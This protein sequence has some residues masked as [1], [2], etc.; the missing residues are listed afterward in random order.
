MWILSTCDYC[1]E[2]CREI[3]LTDIT[4][5][6]AACRQCFE[7]YCDVISHQDDQRWEAMLREYDELYEEHEEIN[8]VHY[9]ECFPNEE[10]YL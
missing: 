3:D 9:G 10:D 5:D 8:P 7:Q 6:A 1:G 2:T 4:D